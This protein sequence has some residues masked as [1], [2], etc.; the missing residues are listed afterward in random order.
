MMDENSYLWPATLG[1]RQSGFFRA[2][3]GA[4]QP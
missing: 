1:T 4:I 2:S 3:P